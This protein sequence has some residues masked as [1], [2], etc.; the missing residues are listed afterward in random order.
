MSPEHHCPLCAA[1]VFLA[2]LQAHLQR[3]HTEVKANPSVQIG[4]EGP[5]DKTR[6]TGVAWLPASN[7]MLFA[8]AHQSGALFVYNK[9]QALQTP[10]DLADFSEACW[11][12][13]PVPRQQVPHCFVVA[14]GVSGKLTSQG[15]SLGRSQGSQHPQ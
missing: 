3:P 11:C 8:V 10:A 1:A 2:N 7:G 13:V 14:G 5:N 15:M 9:V 6:C 12:G 4:T